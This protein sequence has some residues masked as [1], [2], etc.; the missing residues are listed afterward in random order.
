MK[1][2]YVR[3]LVVVCV[4]IALGGCGSGG[5][6]GSQN[7]GVGSTVSM[8]SSITSGSSMAA[9][10]S[11]SDLF[12][13]AGLNFTLTSTLLSTV[14][15]TFTGSTISVPTYQVTY[16]YIGNA[17]PYDTNQY[18][19]PGFTLSFGG[20]VPAAGTWAVT[21]LPTIQASVKTY[22][23]DHYSSAIKCSPAYRARTNFTNYTTNEFR[24]SA[25]VKFNGVEDTTNKSLTTTTN[26]TLFVTR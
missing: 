2:N 25:A 20:V 17:N 15:G 19:I 12:D 10:T 6:S 18:P 23:L 5:S 14:S 26:V 16:T 4:F 9:I 13:Y 24:Y 1:S 22:L 8:T 21:G 11:A 7:L 3:I